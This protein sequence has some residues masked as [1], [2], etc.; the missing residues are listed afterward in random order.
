MREIASPHTLPDTHTALGGYPLVLVIAFVIGFVLTGWKQDP[1]AFLRGNW[2]R[3]L[4]ELLANA[5]ILVACVHVAAVLWIR[6]GLKPLLRH[7]MWLGRKYETKV[8]TRDV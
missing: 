3:D 6:F 7:R 2:P 8:G 5:L 4:H 1:A